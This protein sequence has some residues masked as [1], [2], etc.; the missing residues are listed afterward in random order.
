M[1]DPGRRARHIARVCDLPPRTG[2]SCADQE[3]ELSMGTIAPQNPVVAER[4]REAW[5]RY[6]V[7]LHGLSGAEY[8]A[9]EREAWELLQDELADV[10]AESELEL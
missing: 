5:E 1:T 4:T 6:A 7:T 8:E 10:S 3:R 2:V 9:A